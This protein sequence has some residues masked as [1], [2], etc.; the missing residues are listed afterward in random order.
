MITGYSNDITAVEINPAVITI[1]TRDFY[2]QSGRAYDGLEVFLGNGI[3]YLKRT[4]LKFDMITLMNTHSMSTIGYIGPPDYLH[5]I[6]TYELYFNHLSDNGYLMIEERPLTER[7]MY[8]VKRI[9]ITLYKTL[10]N[11]G[12]DSP[13]EHFFIYSWQGEINI[14]P[15]PGSISE[16]IS[17]L[18]T[19]NPISETIN[20]KILE[21]TNIFISAESQSIRPDFLFNTFDSGEFKEIF[22]GLINNNLSIEN[23]SFNNFSN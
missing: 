12:Y 13:E 17:I 22:I 4:D 14:I 20:E 18:V 2:N 9:I 1:M 15:D 5:T 10:Q 21:W 23:S 11:M 3:S 19:K 6:E 8:G 7:G 16:Y